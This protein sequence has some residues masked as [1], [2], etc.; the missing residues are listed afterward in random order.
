MQTIT[1]L[2][3]ATKP[4]HAQSAALAAEMQAW[5]A[6]RHVRAE[7]LAH[8]ARQDKGAD[9]LRAAAR[10]VDAVVVLGGDGTFI[11]VA[12]QL[13]GQPDGRA[14]P[15]LGI[16]FGHLGFLT[17]TPA[18]DWQI[19]LRRM[20]AGRLCRAPR[21]LLRWALD[22]DGERLLEGNAVNDVVVS[23]GNLARVANIRLSVG[24]KAA[25]RDGI[26]ENPADFSGDDLGWIRA[27]GVIV[28]SPL[29]SS[30]YSLS[31]HGPLAHPDLPI[32][33]VTAVAPFLS[34][35]PPLVLPGDRC[36]RLQCETGGAGGAEICLTVDGQE[37]HALRNKDV[38]SVC[39]LPGGLEM[40]VR[41]PDSHLRTLR[42]R[43]F[44]CGSKHAGAG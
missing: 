38:V 9:L 6:D 21:L 31:A 26:P 13:S 20:L 1:S 37:G 36:V 15:F 27:D 40:L 43:G 23:R 4:G 25:P 3:L 18:K 33:V 34:N 24:R 42:Q 30:A 17:E 28:A 39:G 29:G 14:L 32:L 10:D 41:R 11:G 44:I 7:I 16:N 12:R 35:V 19:V 2:L 5:L 22:R 8:P